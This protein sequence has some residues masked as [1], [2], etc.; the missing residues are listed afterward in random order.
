MTQPK[1]AIRLGTEGKQEVVNDFKAV[2]DAG[3]AAANRASRSFDK[4]ATDFEAAERRMAAAAQKIAAIMPKSALQMQ[5]ESVSGSTATG[6]AVERRPGASS[7]SSLQEGSAR[8]S[9]AAFRELLAEQDRYEASALRLRTAIDPVWAAQQ[10]FNREMGEARMLVANGSISLDEYCAKLRLEQTALDESS[11]AHGRMTTSSGAMRA[12]LQQAG[13]QVQDF[14][15]QINGG[16]DAVRA[17]SMQAP[18]LIGDLQMMTHGAEQG[19]GRFAKFA[20]LLGGPWGVALGIAI[21]VAGMLAETLF[22]DADASKAA[23]EAAKKHRD[24]VEALNREMRQ[25]IQTAEDKARANYIL[26]ESDRLAAIQAERRLQA[27]LTMARLLAKNAQGSSL[28]AGGPGG[29]QSIV[30]SQYAAQVERIESDLKKSQDRIAELSG[31]SAIAMGRYQATIIDQ[32]MTPSGRV[33]RDYDRRINDAIGRGDAEAI[34]KLTR[35]RD[36]ELKKIEDSEKALRSSASARHDGDAATTSQVSKMLLEAFGGTITSTTGGKHVKGSY[37][38]RG[39]AVDFVPSGGMGSISKS[40]IRTLLEGAGLSI[41]ELLG[42][43]D[44]DHDD[45]FHVAWAGGKGAVDSAR[46][47]GGMIAEETRKALQL[48]SQRNGWANEQAAN[49]GKASGAWLTAEGDKI[50]DRNRDY[51]RQLDDMSGG[52]ALLNLEWQLRGRNRDEAQRILEVERYRLDIMRQYPTLTADQVAELVKAKEK[53]VEMNDLVASM[54]DY[55]MDWAEI[56]KDAV[57]RI[58]DITSA[59]SWG[60]RVMSILVEIANEMIRM[61]AIQLF[62]GSKQGGGGGLFGT[63]LGGIVS[64]VGGGGLG[65][66]SASSQSYLDGISAQLSMPRLLGSAIGNEYTPAG[67]M[68]VGENGPEVVDMP[69]GA[70]VMTASD[71]RRA[72]AGGQRA[73]TYAPV[74]QID[75]TGADPASLMRVEAKLDEMDRSFSS[76]TLNTVQ[77]ASDRLYLRFGG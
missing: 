66:I 10:H 77:E 62:M 40:E 57:S 22:K 69:R 2:G 32:M 71:T 47:I 38:Y 35:A 36:A 44:K 67:A 54:R 33:K 52:T 50:G 76:R 1:V 17:F 45:H 30:A 7:I 19:E 28:A 13:F 43:G 6:G 51:Q 20:G 37:H 25:S 41:K 64:A 61:Q 16:T 29:A 31:T 46:I 39:Q 74:Y 65:G 23:E 49:A 21:P 63:L 11:K 26:L 55:T 15:V 9:A 48:E 12:G 14:F 27:E 24:A 59:Q 18:Q 75:A 53:Q 72:M 56:G 58:F 68:L 5:I 34:A 70:K 42:P 4:A 3:D 8:I 60:D 73:I